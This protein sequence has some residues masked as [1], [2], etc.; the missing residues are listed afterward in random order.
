MTPDNFSPELRPHLV[1]NL[2]GDW[3]FAPPPLPPDLPAPSWADTVHIAEAERAVSELKGL[4]ANLPNPHLLAGAFAR[5]EATLSSRIE[6]TQSDLR[7]LLLFE[8]GD[9]AA[10]KTDAREIANY[11][12]ALEHGLKRIGEVPLCLNV[13]LEMHG[14]LLRGDVRGADQTSGRWREGKVWIGPHGCEIANATYVPPP[15][16]EARAA[17]NAL[18][19]YLHDDSPLP[20]LV[21]LALIHYQFEAIHPFRDG[22]G[23][24]GRL[25]IPLL[26]CER[27][28][29]G[30]PLLYLSAFFERHRDE[31]YELLL[32]V[33]LR[34]DWMSWVSFFVR[35][36]KEEGRDGVLRARHLLNLREKYR[37]QM[38]ASRVAATTLLV[39]DTLF[40]TP[41][42]SPVGVREQLAISPTTIQSAIER[43]ENEGIVQEI[44]GNK[45]NRIYAAAE[46]LDVLQGDHSP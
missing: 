27:G 31:Y 10:Q 33:S 7:G 42:F 26:L 25:L 18:E 29:L 2:D 40:S 17:M 46:I 9:F 37:E 5:R 20:F 43:L 44:S 22:N 21:R 36:M 8:A 6:G 34:G 4:A 45:R 16:P 11:V 35:G 1:K 15:A 13:L 28:F 39:V 32:R 23:R 19:R 41:V 12:A 14:L 24:I 30:Q 38:S 3:S